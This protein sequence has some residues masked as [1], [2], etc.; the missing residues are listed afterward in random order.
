[1]SW[2]FL[3]TNHDQDQ[4][5]VLI[6]WIAVGS[7]IS[8]YFTLTFYYRNTFKESCTLVKI[9]LVLYPFVS[10]LLWIHML[11]TEVDLDFFYISIK[12]FLE[13]IY[14]FKNEVSITSYIG[15]HMFFVFVFFWNI[16]DIF[17][18][19]FL[20]PQNILLFFHWKDHVVIVFINIT[21]ICSYICISI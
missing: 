4:T 12:E 9:I 8:L 1:M 11:K 20:I 21:W 6:L 18:H 3:L 16:F 5:R 17:F 19:S 7:Y 10:R 14:F 13:N 15:L 2:N